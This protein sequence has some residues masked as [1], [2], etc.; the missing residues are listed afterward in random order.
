[1]MEGL[2]QTEGRCVD[3]ADCTR[4]RAK[5]GMKV[6]IPKMAINCRLAR[7][8]NRLRLKPIRKPCFLE[9]MY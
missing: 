3:G 7:C 4:E 6:A 2:Q 5:V 8:R 9:E 1:M